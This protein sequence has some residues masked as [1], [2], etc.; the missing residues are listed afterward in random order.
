[1]S[2]AMP[3]I[4]CVALERGFKETLDYLIPPQ[5]Q[6]LVQLGHI[7]KVPIQRQHEMG[8]VLALKHTSEFEKKLRCIEEI[9]E[10]DCPLPEDLL[11]L[12]TWMSEYYACS[13]PRI[14]QVM[15][16]KSIRQPQQAPQAPLFVTRKQSLET[17][18]EKS[19]SLR[20]KHSS[21]SRVLDI[22][23]KVKSGILLS[24]LI[25]RAETSAS[26]IHTLVK[27]GILDI[28]P[29]PDTLDLSI[30]RYFTSNPKSLNNEQQVALE[31]II[32]SLQ[33]E[34]PD[35]HLLL[36]VT[37][38][39]KTEVYLQAIQ[40]VLEGTGS[41]LLMV[42]EVAL[43]AQTIDRIRARFDCPIA[44]LHYRISPRERQKQWQSILSGQARIIIGAR[45]SIFC[46]A[47]KL[48]L[49]IVDEEHEGSY[50]S[51]ESPHY[52]ARDLA[53]QRA[54][55]HGATVILGSA[56]PSLESYEKAISGQYHLLKLQERASL[57][58]LPPV[59]IVDMLPEYEKS[60]F[61][62]F[63][64][65]LLEELKNTLQ[66]GEQALIF[67]NR[68]G[69]FTQIQCSGCG[70]AVSCPH[71]DVKLTFH[72]NDQKLVCHLC[73]YTSNT[74]EKCP[75]CSK[76]GFLKF[77]GWGTEHVQAFLH[78]LLPDARS[79][80][81]DGDTTRHKG[82]LEQLLRE[83]RTHKADILIG[84]QM[85]AKGHHFPG[86]T[87]VGVLNP[88]AELLLPDFRAGE[89]LF[90]LLVQVFGRSGRSHLHGKVI[91]QTAQA[92]APLYRLAADH[93]YLAFAE[94]ELQMRKIFEYPPFTHLIKV[95]VHGPTE[96]AV[97]LAS[98]H[99]YQDLIKHLPKSCLISSPGDGAWRKIQDRWRQVFLI[100]TKNPSTI[101]N[102]LQLCRSQAEKD[103][104]TVHY[105]IDCQSIG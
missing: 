64:N 70:N 46:P 43:T 91:V 57:A 96:Q 68:R 1:M 93:N 79:I 81:M 83:F 38:S 25:E 39:G 29:M 49:I 34:K 94:Q 61:T 97:L 5:M 55:Q 67:L 71:C 51:E 103:Q 75:T 48:R 73:H 80:R 7:V 86:L 52:H 4:A 95:S 98:N 99:L 21:R 32:K 78:R 66:R 24:E 88:D 15:I 69:Y 56:T 89:R 53:I 19:S 18:A 44:I 100:K 6:G 60:G 102:A 3:H 28:Q 14:L 58:K 105:D 26:P 84:T 50:K 77:K 85:I 54:N 104:I 22:M 92:T 31:A 20:A 37:G 76:S 33:T 36:G 90:Q 47:P 30:H 8:V 11:K 12:A 74:P 59:Q 101:T 40:K 13:L 41:C 63:S 65:I 2:F 16:P 35:V 45:S 72:K 42:P 9:V 10:P 27:D 82:S 62:L 17:I 23:L 87:L